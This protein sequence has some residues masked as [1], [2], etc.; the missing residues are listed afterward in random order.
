M[1]VGYEDVYGFGFFGVF[2]V[3][4]GACSA[5]FGGLCCS[6][7]FVLCWVLLLGEGV[8]CVVFCYSC[9]FIL[10][11]EDLVFCFLFWVFVLVYWWFF[12]LFPV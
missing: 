7:V 8:V 11:G 1:G 6:F 10:L 2:L 9:G 3:V 12:L 4:L 5:C